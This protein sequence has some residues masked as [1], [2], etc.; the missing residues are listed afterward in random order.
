MLA[1]QRTGPALYCL[2]GCALVFGL[3]ISMGVLAGFVRSRGSWLTWR[4]EPT[5]VAV[6]AGVL[7]L[8][9]AILR[10]VAKR[11]RRP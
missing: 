6:I 2:A 3:P 7:V 5:T 9:L 10:A 8:S 1:D 11:N 4:F